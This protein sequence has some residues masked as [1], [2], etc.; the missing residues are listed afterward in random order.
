MKTLINKS[1]ISALSFLFVIAFSPMATAAENPFG[2]SNTLDM[3]LADSHKQGKCGEG[4]CGASMK[5]KS[6]D[7][8]CGKGK[9]GEG[10]CGAS[11]KEK[12][13]DGKCGEGKC[14]ANMKEK[15]RDGKCGRGNKSKS[16]EPKCGASE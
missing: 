10:K 1:I 15:S 16:E 4:K 13:R 5:E 8:K 7:G 12:S 11:M 6:R 9:C 2:M 3:Q 14:G